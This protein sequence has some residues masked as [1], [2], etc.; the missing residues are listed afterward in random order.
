MDHAMNFRQEIYCPILEFIFKPQSRNPYRKENCIENPKMTSFAEASLEE[1][2]MTP[3]V[4]QPSPKNNI[5]RVE[6]D[7]RE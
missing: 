1:R 2:A 3:N 6:I 7:K 5:K 4:M